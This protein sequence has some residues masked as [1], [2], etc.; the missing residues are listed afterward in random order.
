MNHLS[1]NKDIL[2][3]VD[4]VNSISNNLIFN[5]WI[6]HKKY[7]II[8]I[9]IGDENINFK[10]FPR[11]DV[12]NVYTNIPNPN[13]VGFQ[14]EISKNKLLQPVNIE[15]SNGEKIKI[16]SLEKFYIFYLGFNKKQN[17]SIIVV[18]N[19][20]NNPDEIRNFA[21]N[22]LEY[23]ESGYHKGK[24][25]TERF[26]LKGTK[27]IFE[28]ILGKQIF[29]WNKE[30]YA[31]GIFQFC[32]KNDPI[33]YHTDSQNY[34]GIIFLSPDAPVSTGTATYKSKITGVSKIDDTNYSEELY[35]K[36][37]SGYGDNIN[38]YDNSSYELVDKIGNVYNRLLLFDS[39]YIHAATE[40][41]GND[42]NN[43]R[44]FQLFFF[45]IK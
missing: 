12:S 25:S 18:D 9:Q 14:I 27:E 34:A 40:Y 36:T 6:F 33:V 30:S 7:D 5:G 13:K 41:Y 1:K 42:I 38:F 37:F 35:K 24:R 15:L 3:Y 45:D 29:N 28:N 11:L 43:S 10:Q 17:K 16:E 31:N 19:F 4:A 8:N 32:T 44:F 26:I 22:N 21:I 2:W 39:K 23:K 20:Y